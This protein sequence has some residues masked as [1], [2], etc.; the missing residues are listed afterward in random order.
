M[1][2]AGLSVATISKN[3]LCELLKAKCMVKGM[4]YLGKTVK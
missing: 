1:Y 4:D 3:L 2:G